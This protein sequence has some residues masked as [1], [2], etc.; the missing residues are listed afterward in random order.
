MKTTL[1]VIGMSLGFLCILTSSYFILYASW[2]CW[3][4]RDGMGPKAVTS[5]GIL[6]LSHFWYL[7]E[8]YPHLV[9]YFLTVMF[10]FVCILSSWRVGRKNLH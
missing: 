3:I 2:A 8:Q 6:A 7:F 1:K 4:L 9:Y 10:G 5:T